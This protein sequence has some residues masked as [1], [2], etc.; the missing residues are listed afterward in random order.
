MTGAN[1]K[2]LSVTWSARERDAG[3]RTGRALLFM[4]GNTTYAVS[5]NFVR[6][7]LEMPLVAKVAGAQPWL[8]GMASCE[9]AAVPLINTR[10]LLHPDSGSP[11]QVCKRAIVIDSAYGTCLLAVEQ[12]N[13]LSDLS[14]AKRHAKLPVEYKAP[15]IEYSCE[16]NGV[17]VGVIKV[18]SLFQFTSERSMHSD[19]DIA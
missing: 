15:F 16:S 12:I 19:G 17:T 9:G 7:V 8:S 2:A 10:R 14:N 1:Q 18:A 13:T 6:R 4:L 3:H 11:S 5:V